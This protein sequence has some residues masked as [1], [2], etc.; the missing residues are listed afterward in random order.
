MPNCLWEEQQTQGSC[1]CEQ[2]L[3]KCMRREAYCSLRL[4]MD[5]QA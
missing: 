2:A 4:A 3:Q 1:E 5:L